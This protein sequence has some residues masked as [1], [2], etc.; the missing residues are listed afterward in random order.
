MLLPNLR[1]TVKQA[2]QNKEHSSRVKDIVNVARSSVRVF[3]FS[4]L[5]VSATFAVVILVIL[6]KRKI[7]V[8]AILNRNLGLK[9]EDIVVIEFLAEIDGEAFEAEIR[10]FRI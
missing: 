10:N 9:R 6:R 4:G 8:Q 5:A 2:F 3:C 1:D 7:N